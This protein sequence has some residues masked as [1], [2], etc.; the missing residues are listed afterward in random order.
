MQRAISNHGHETRHNCTATFER[1]ARFRCHCR[2]RL[3]MRANATAI[4]VGVLVTGL[5]LLL[6]NA[7]TRASNLQLLLDNA[8]L[9]GKLGAEPHT[10]IDEALRAALIGLKAL[11]P[12]TMAQAA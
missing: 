3:Q 12:A 9:V 8:R 7:H 4:A 10:P 6:L 1:H 11:P 2:S 5:C